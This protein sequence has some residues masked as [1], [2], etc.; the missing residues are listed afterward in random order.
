MSIAGRRSWLEEFRDRSGLV[1]KTSSM[2][3]AVVEKVCTKEMP[4]FVLKWWWSVG[5]NSHND[6][7]AFSNVSHSTEGWRACSSCK[8]KSSMSERQ[9][10]FTTSLT[11]DWKVNAWVKGD[12]LS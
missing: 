6:K 2:W 4:N 7:G 9:G 11:V 10:F 12:R 3:A 8:K 1:D 5:V